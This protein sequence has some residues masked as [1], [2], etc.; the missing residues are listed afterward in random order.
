MSDP[1]WGNTPC[2]ILIFNYLFP[3]PLH[4]PLH[5]PGSMWLG[6]WGQMSCWIH[7]MGSPWHLLGAKLG[8]EMQLSSQ[9]LLP[10]CVLSPMSGC[11]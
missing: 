2:G 6:S 3:Q 11:F 9:P 4:T 10:A 1:S 5:C 7:G 8:S